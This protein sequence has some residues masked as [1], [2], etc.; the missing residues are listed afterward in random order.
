MC[1]NV[2]IQ[3]MSHAQTD[4]SVVAIAA[5]VRKNNRTGLYFHPSSARSESD[6]AVSTCDGGVAYSSGVDLTEVGVNGRGG[7]GSVGRPSL[8]TS[9]AD[10]GRA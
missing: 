7:K 2:D 8:D 6:L 10:E 3:S 1:D 9:P 5:E 4:V